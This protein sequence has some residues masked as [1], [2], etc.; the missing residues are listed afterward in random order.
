MMDVPFWEIRSSPNSRTPCTH[1]PFPFL[2]SLQSFA[3]LCG[4]Y[5]LGRIQDGD[6]QSGGGRRRLRSELTLVSRL[7]IVGWLAI[8]S[9]VGGAGQDCVLY[10]VARCTKN[11]GTT[12][13]EAYPSTTVIHT[14]LSLTSRLM[15]ILDEDRHFRNT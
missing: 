2:S 13:Q 11:F 12:S 4:L 1:A 3:V 15:M 9:L 10:H 14:G 8:T 7:K 6:S 5:C